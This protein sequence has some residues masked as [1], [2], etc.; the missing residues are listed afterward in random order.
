MYTLMKMDNNYE[1]GPPKLMKEEDVTE[2]KA[3]SVFP[4]TSFFNQS[5]F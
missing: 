4:K 2:P 3:V 5:S 1:C